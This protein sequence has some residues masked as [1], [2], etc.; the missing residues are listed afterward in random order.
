LRIDTHRV[1]AGV[2]DVGIGRPGDYEGASRGRVDQPAYIAEGYAT[3][4]QAQ[5]GR[6]TSRPEPCTTKLVHGPDLRAPFGA[7]R[8]IALNAAGRVR[9][10]GKHVKEQGDQ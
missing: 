3:L 10:H 9:V 4:D 7:G 6:I 5:G 1:Q 8:I 2:V